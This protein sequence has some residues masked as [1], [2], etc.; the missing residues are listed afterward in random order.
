M[1]IKGR[2]VPNTEYITVKKLGPDGNIG[3]FVGDKQATTYLGCDID[4]IDGVKENVA[5]MLEQ[6]PE[7]A[8]FHV[9][10]FGYSPDQYAFSKAKDEKLALWMDFNRHY[11]WC[12]VKYTNGML[13]DWVIIED[14]WVQE[15]CAAA[16]AEMC[17]FAYFGRRH[18]FVESVLTQSAQVTPGKIAKQNVNGGG[19]R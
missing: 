19:Q 15:H 18:R 3:V 5:L 16:C 4:N 10:A 1:N 17:S 11:A 13:G 14:L 12:R 8:E 6:H 9:G 7:I 2:S